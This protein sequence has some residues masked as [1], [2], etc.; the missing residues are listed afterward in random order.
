[1]PFFLRKFSYMLPI[2]R[3]FRRLVKTTIFGVL[4]GALDLGFRSE[5]GWSNRH[6]DF[7]QRLPG[8]AKARPEYTRVVVGKVRVQIL[9]KKTGPRACPVGFRVPEMCSF[10]I[11]PWAKQ[12]VDWMQ[13]FW[14]GK[15]AASRFCIVSRSYPIGP[16]HIINES[17]PP[18][19]LV[20]KCAVCPASRVVVVGGEAWGA[21]Q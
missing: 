21:I 16:P 4:F 2:C 19:C 10:S 5:I 20:V 7:L 14:P 18:R 8:S 13:S 17:S 15:T 3:S 9:A 6:P 11:M 1:M 12:E